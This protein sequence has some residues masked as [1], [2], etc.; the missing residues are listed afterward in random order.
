MWQRN[1]DL[2]VVEREESRLAIQHALIPVF[3]DLIGQDDDVA[4]VE[5]QLSL[6][7][8]LEVVQGLTARLLWSW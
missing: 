7:F 3:I 1:E 8:W 2:H 4:F 5:A 6:I